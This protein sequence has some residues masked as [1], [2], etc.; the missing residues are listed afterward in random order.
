MSSITIVCRDVDHQNAHA[1]ALSA[2]LRA[3]GIGVKRCTAPPSVRTEV[4]AC[5]GWRMGQRLRL[6]GAD[7]LVMERGYLGDRFKWTSLCWNG[8]N[9]YGAFPPT[10]HDGGERFNTHHGY[11]MQPWRDGG[12]YVLIIGQV[13]GDASLKGRDLRPW[14]ADCARRAKVFGLPI[15]FRPHPL[16]H[17]RGGVHAVPGTVMQQGTLGEALAGAAVTI[18]Y[19]S[20]T[21]V[22]S[23]LAGVPTICMDRGSMAY[24]MCSHDFDAPLIRP[25]RMQWAHTLAWRQWSLDEI[26]SGEA[27]RSFT[28]RQSEVA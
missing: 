22:E 28:Q 11:L 19:N 3:L 7:V 24:D 15:V 26:S 25:D 23:V 13:P 16:A 6:A 8:L 1:E 20:N 4:A 21:A 27:L 17:R 10:P 2:G 12:D 18:V 9:G 14:Y 5:W